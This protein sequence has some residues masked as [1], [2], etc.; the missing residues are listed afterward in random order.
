MDPLLATLDSAHGPASDTKPQPKRFLK[1]V[2]AAPRQQLK[3]IGL[4]ED[5]RI[6]GKKIVGGALAV[7]GKLIH[8]VAFP[9]A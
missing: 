2:Q 5:V 7:D 6:N 9:A 4:G 8:L 3:A 1:A